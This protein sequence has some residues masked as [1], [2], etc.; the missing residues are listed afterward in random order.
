MQEQTQLRPGDIFRVHNTTAQAHRVTLTTS[1]GTVIRVMLH[2]GADIEMVA[3]TEPMQ[4]DMAALD[5]AKG[6][7][8][9]VD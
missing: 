2:P 1:A 5:D 6:Q 4:I 8:H 7:L 9:A 3:G